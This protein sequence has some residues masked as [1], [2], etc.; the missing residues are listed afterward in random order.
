MQPADDTRA[1]W[2]PL[3]NEIPLDPGVY[4]FADRHGRVLYIGK[5]QSLRNR[6]QNYFGPL[7]SLAP[8]TQ[9][10][11]QLARQV[12]WTVVANDTEALLLEHTWIREYTPPFNVQ[13]RDDK[14]YP[15]L[16]LTLGDEAPRLIMTRKSGIAG[17]K[18]FGPYPKVWA[19]RQ[20]MQA[21]QDAFPIRTCKDSDYQRAISTGR[22]CLA[23]QIGSC[24]GPCSGN[25]T[26]EEHRE[27]VRELDAFLSGQD[28]QFMQR[29]ETAM[30]KASAEMRY[31]E[32]ASY[33]DQL[34][35]A[36][37]ALEQNAIVLRH[38]QDLD[39]FGVAMDD[40]TAAVHQFIVRKG[41]IRGEHSWVVDV[42]LDNTVGRLM[43]FALQNAY[44]NQEVP[45]T[46]LVQEMPDSATELAEALRIKR[47]RRGLV[48]L[49]VPERGE[50]QRLMERATLNAQEQLTRAKLKRASDIVT[51]TDALAQLQESLELDEPPLRIECIDV[52]HLQGTNVVASLVVFEDG[53]PARSE[54]RKYAIEHTS[55]DTDSVYQV[56]VRRATRMQAE[57]EAHEPGSVAATR[58][59]PQLFVIDGGLPQVNAAARAL[60]E[61]GFSHIAVCGLAKR[62][63]EIWLPRSEFPVILPRSSEA[64]FLLQRIRD[65]A[66]RVAITY[67]RA[68][69]RRDIR[70]QLSEVPGLGPKRSQQLLR[71][72]G[73]ATRLRQASAEEIGSVPGIGPSL[74]VSI[75]RHLSARAHGNL[76]VEEND[77][78]LGGG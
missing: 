73:S 16:A 68:K 47:P 51:R 3:S 25:V 34:E 55:D 44:E 22:P 40:L 41:R 2:R 61:A 1:S 76:R 31:E 45:A 48:H 59:I 15:Y 58:T 27:T 33:R 13:F 39:V 43:E 64:L 26:L 17:A 24:H 65:E 9:R 50:K 12:D 28:R 46:I 63:E 49:Y 54:Y 78:K 66:H 29:L 60:S 74:A 77:E 70:S 53:L 37:L 67:Q 18:Y 35:G 7:S 42:E 11:L 5:A 52:S 4:R 14:S 38:A 69:R 23:G 62:M 72:F 36:R 56:M 19:I 71:H 8:R 6:L 75:A 32:A 21:L 57:L 30:R 20:L 10:M